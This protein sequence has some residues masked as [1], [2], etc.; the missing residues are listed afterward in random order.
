MK[1]SNNVETVCLVLMVLAIWQGSHQV[2]N[3]ETPPSGQKETSVVDT[4]LEAFGGNS[5]KVS[6]KIPDSKMQQ[7]IDDLAYRT[8]DCGEE[9]PISG[10]IKDMMAQ[11]LAAC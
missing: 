11:G 2:S 7:R 3:G 6:G 5:T 1:K 9:E 4:T 10:L 8:Y